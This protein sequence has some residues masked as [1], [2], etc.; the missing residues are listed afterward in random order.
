MDLWALPEMI[1][2]EPIKSCTRYISE[3][4]NKY[5]IHW[6]IKPI[7]T[8]FMLNWWA[9]HSWCSIALKKKK[10]IVS[11][12]NFSL[13][14]G[15]EYHWWVSDM[16]IKTKSKNWTEINFILLNIT[17]GLSQFEWECCTTEWK[18]NM[19]N[20]FARDK[21]QLSKTNWCLAFLMGHLRRHQRIEKRSWTKNVSHLVSITS[22]YL[23]IPSQHSKLLFHFLEF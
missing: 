6:L 10:T 21:K 7:S 5:R 17:A 14:Q 15:Y 13:T 22:K 20:E 18:L 2:F 8:I 19:R 9:M 16:K 23:Y 3:V 12:F 1:I 11:N 4:P